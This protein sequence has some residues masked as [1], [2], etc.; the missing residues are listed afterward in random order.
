MDLQRRLN[1]LEQAGIQIAGISCDRNEILRR[2]SEQNSITFPLLS[3]ESGNGGT[4]QQYGLMDPREIGK[5]AGVP[6][7]TVVLV[8]QSQQIRMILRGEVKQRPG[9]DQLIDGLPE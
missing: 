6:V 5:Y 9:I 1:E 3:D 8:D 7:P 4:I 2:F